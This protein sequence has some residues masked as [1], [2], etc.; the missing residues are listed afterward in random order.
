MKPL[1][2]RPEYYPRGPLSRDVRGEERKGGGISDYAEVLP[3]LLTAVG[4]PGPAPA[5]AVPKR[6]VKQS[7]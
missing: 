1:I 2:R 6:P 4:V 7:L 3:A 5:L